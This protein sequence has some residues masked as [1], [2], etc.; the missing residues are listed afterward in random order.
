M[1]TLHTLHTVFHTLR[2]LRTLHTLYTFHMRLVQVYAQQLFVDGLFN[3]DPH[4]GNLMV[5]VR[6]GRALPVLLDFGM[7]VRCSEAQHVVYATYVPCVTGVT[8]VACVTGVTGVTRLSQ[9]PCRWLPRR[10]GWA[11][12]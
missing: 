10:S 3:A 7:T 9:L 1:H 12:T 2:T 5:Q 8:G 4:P 11:V 6:E